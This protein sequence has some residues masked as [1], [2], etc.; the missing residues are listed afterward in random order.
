LASAQGIKM[1]QNKL[2]TYFLGA[3]TCVAIVYSLIA[4][5]NGYR[6][7]QLNQQAPLQTIQWAVV[8]TKRGKFLLEG[9]YRFEV[10]QKSYQGKTV[11]D[12][13]VYWN[14]WSAL[15]SKEEIAKQYRIAWYQNTAP[16]HSS[17]VK[18]FPW[19]SF[20]TAFFMWALLLYFYYIKARVN[21]YLR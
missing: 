1:D 21:A 2:W 8:P 15:S 6:Y 14:E 10:G 20:A 19:K 5:M 12:S 7:V 4:F 13:P 3:L 11:L 17:L 9:D 18:F 16:K